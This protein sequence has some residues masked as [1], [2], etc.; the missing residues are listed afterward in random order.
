MLDLIFQ[1]VFVSQHP[2][3]KKGKKVLST[4]PNDMIGEC[5]LFFSMPFA[6]SRNCFCAYNKENMVISQKT[7]PVWYS[8]LL[9]PDLSF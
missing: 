9:E 4:D 3:S 7:H 1:L 8:L 5:F 2:Y 6:I